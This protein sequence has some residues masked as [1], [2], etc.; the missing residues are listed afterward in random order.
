MSKILAYYDVKGIQDFIFA[1]N[2]LKENVGASL[3]VLKVLDSFLIEAIKETCE[4]GRRNVD[5]KDFPGIQMKEKDLDAE[6]IYSGGGNAMVG[7]KNDTVYHAVNSALSRKILMETGGA[8]QFTSACTDTDFSDSKF[9]EVRQA[10]VKK[11]EKI[12]YETVQTSPLMGIAIT[13]E[14]K[15]D[16]LP[17][18]V[19]ETPK[20]TGEKEFLS[21]PARKKRDQEGKEYYEKEKIKILDHYH[22]TFPPEFDDLGREKGESHIAV[23][24]IDGNNMGQKIKKL[25][26]YREMK[27]FSKEITE[28]YEKT[29]FSVIETLLDE[30]N[31]GKLFEKL[32][33]KVN[34]DK[35]MFLPV[36]IIVL[37]GDDV[38]FVTD[39]R[40]GVPLAELFLKKINESPIPLDDRKIPLSACAGVAIV[41][42]HF[43]FFRAY[44]LA[45]ELC[46][47]A[48]LKG[49]ILAGQKKDDK[50]MGNWLD[51]HIVYS[52]ITT[53]LEQLR[54]RQY[55]IP[56]FP[57]AESLK[58]PP[59]SES[60]EMEQKQYNLLH[61]PWC[62][63]GDCDEKYKWSNL[64]KILEEFKD[65]QEWPRSRLKHLRNESI[66]SKKAISALLAEYESRD[67]VLPDFLEKKDYLDEDNGTPYFDALELLDFYELAIM[68]E[69]G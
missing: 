49:K 37:N 39:G 30:L 42:S 32:N 58:Y 26:S 1:S 35:K 52:G 21:I 64:K 61:R 45:D 29:M 67:L 16:G 47:T 3:L 31:K 22:Y 62:A 15:T 18:Q 65:E 46:K 63:A 34:E 57:G 56:G 5:W 24:H 51:F 8:I 25:N 43:P 36:R 4:E 59:R 55:N 10:V 19:M 11:L 9:Q 50:E 66:K 38:T 54:K 2:K 53:D 48:K 68:E 13:R 12:K 27:K 44:Q 41:K 28:T 6:I 33:L 69:E 7:Y 20:E 14:G 60:P 23:V 17:A 40:L